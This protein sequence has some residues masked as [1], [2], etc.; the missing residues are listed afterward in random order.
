MQFCDIKTAVSEIGSWAEGYRLDQRMSG[1]KA[2]LQLGWWPE[3]EDVIAEVS[4]NFCW[5]YCA[6]IFCKPS[7]WKVNYFG[8]TTRGNITGL[9]ARR[10]NFLSS[11]GNICGA[12][13]SKNNA[14]PNNIR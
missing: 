10:A 4:G 9:F 11:K 1:E 2:R 14:E 6:F 5:S 8:T 13:V 12:M 7:L 3:Y